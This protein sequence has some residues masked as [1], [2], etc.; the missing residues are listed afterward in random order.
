MMDV[1]LLR[2]KQT[3]LL[4][5]VI[6]FLLVVLMNLVL[7]AHNL[8]KL[9]VPMNRI[10]VLGIQVPLN[11]LKQL[12]A[13]MRHPNNVDSGQIV[14]LEHSLHARLPLVQQLISARPLNVYLHLL[15]A[16]SMQHH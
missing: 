3:V 16:Q 13:K 4:L 11:A 5:N 1:L 7:T 9:N 15:A 6:I 12:L 2:H 8:I 10:T 14:V